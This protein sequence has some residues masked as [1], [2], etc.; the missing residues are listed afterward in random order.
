MTLDAILP[1][2]TAWIDRYALWIYGAAALG[3]LLCIRAIWIARREKK[4][5]IFKLERELAMSRESRAFSTAALLV[6]IIVAVSG[7]KFY[8][9]PNIDLAPPTATPTP[10]S[11]LFEEPPTREVP[12]ATPAEPLATSTPRPTERPTEPPAPP[13]AT[14]LPAVSCANPGS[15]ITYP[16][17]GMRV[18]GAVQVRGTAN[19]AQ[20]QFYKVEYGL[21]EEPQQWHSL[22]DIHR[23]PVANG[24]LDTWNATG[25]PAGVYKLRLTVVDVSGNWTTPHEVRVIIP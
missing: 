11:F 1:R 7:F 5:S 17:A 24:V 15:C 14:A 3:L 23:Q 16:V 2:M 13:T 4:Q 18:S 25:F 8:L 19:I 21:G 10:T 6:G 12:T 20:F 22:S 9:A